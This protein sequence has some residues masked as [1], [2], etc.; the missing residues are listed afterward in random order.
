LIYD[1][2]HGQYIRELFKQGDRIVICW[3]IHT[4]PAFHQRFLVGACRR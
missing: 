1:Y 2:N 4:E 3:K